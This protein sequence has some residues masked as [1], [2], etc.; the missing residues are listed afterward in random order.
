MSDKQTAYPPPHQA[1]PLAAFTAGQAAV[2]TSFTGGRKLQERMVAL[3]LFPGQLL[4]ICQNNGSSL[5]VSLNGIVWH[6]AG[7]SAKKYWPHQPATAVTNTKHV[8]CP[9]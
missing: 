1:Q 6:W 9:M 7:A 2:I 4:T 3:G 5:V 8:Q